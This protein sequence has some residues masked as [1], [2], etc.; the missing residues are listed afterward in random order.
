M[1]EFSLPHMVEP[2][3]AGGLADSVYEL[4]D[5]E[6]DRVQ[7]ARRDPA[8]RDQW[9]PVTAA[10]FRDE[11]L[12]LAKGLLVEGVRFGDRVALMAR[13]RYEWT[14]FSYALWS[15]GAQ[16][17][18]VYPTS[19]AE[20]V[21][22]ILA[23]TRAVAV[24]VEGEDDAMTVGAVC[25]TVPA[26]R[27]IWQMDRGCVTELWRRGA[28]VHEELVTERRWLVEPRCTAVICYTS[29]TTGQPL[30]CMITH[31]NLAAECDTLF[32]GWSGLFAEPGQK[33]AVLAFLPLA[34]IYG[35]MVQVLCVRSGILMGHEPELSP[36]SLLPSFQSF[37]P[38]CVFAVPYIFERILGAARTA[39]QDSGK[40]SLFERAMDTAVRYAE[41]VERQTQGAGRGPG[42]GLRAAHAVFDHMVYRRLRAVLGGRVRYAV[43]GG[44]PF[45]R[46]LGLMF[47][48]AGITVYNGYGLTETT[49]AVTAQ[50]P[51]R[52]RHGTV[53]RPMPGTAV[54]IAPDG[55]VW[56]RG[57]TVFAGYVD[58]PKATGAAL[59]DGWLHTG[60]V[61]FLDSEGYLT[62]T[63][64]KKD[65]II[66]SGGKSVS[67]L[68]LEERLRA[69]PLISQCVLVGDNRPFVGALITLDAEMLRRWHQVVGARLP[70]GREHASANQ[71]LHAE[72]QQAVSTA[73][74]SVSRAESIRAFRILPKDFT[75]ADGL[76]TPSLK[77]RRDAVYKL[78]AAQIEQL[79]AN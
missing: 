70:V 15:V 57:G 69:H 1:R 71:A 7:F 66:T 75:V 3:R 48:G 52:P 10:A 41:A 67:P 38:T 14:L 77:L 45:S 24:V 55:E 23:Q 31:A 79:Y 18:T 78:C 32:A 59:R 73:N 62:I 54:R 34:H 29:G 43:T 30:G 39:A 42:P 58:D 37:H 47:A 2:L 51:G 11:V 76:L 35:L 22:W 36:S 28:G 26:L 65:I 40:G 20:Q 72:I 21:G 5:R 61:G 46:E 64:R 60:D 50:P 6:P 16:V 17:V 13:T 56:V 4:A 8:D 68:P 27:S 25:D 33:P 49:A 74:L 53:G 44:S 12:A 19:S 9:T 63:G